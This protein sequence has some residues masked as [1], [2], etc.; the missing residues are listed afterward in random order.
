MANLSAAR[1][2]ARPVVAGV[3]GPVGE[4]RAIGLRSRQNIVLVRR[5]AASIDDLTLLGELRFLGELDR[6]SVV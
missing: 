5:I 6:K 4:G 3:I 1:G 2:I